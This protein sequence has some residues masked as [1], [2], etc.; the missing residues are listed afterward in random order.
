MNKFPKISIITPSYNQGQ[1]I[2]ETINSVLS[3]NYPNL[4]Y[5]IIDGG[6]NDNTVDV[7]K[8]YEKYL[9]YWVSEADNGQAHAIN[10]GF[11]KAT[12]EII[13][14]LNSDDLL[15]QGALFTIANRFSENQDI[16]FI[17]GQIIEFDENGNLPFK[18]FPT[19]DLP[20]R[21]FYD[22]PYAQ[23]A[24]FYKK[25]IVKGLG[26]LDENFQFTMD[27]DLFVRIL[28]KHKAFQIN[29]VLARFRWHSDSKSS[30]LSKIANHERQLVF[31]A[32]YKSAGFT[33]S[34]QLLKQLGLYVDSEKHYIITHSALLTNQ[35]RI[36]FGY[37]LPF[38]NRYYIGGDYEKVREILRF[39]RLHAPEY[40]KHTNIWRKK[41]MLRF[42]DA[43]IR[44]YQKLKTLHNPCT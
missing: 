31:S 25:D 2:E 22:F 40:L 14:W 8:K 33:N 19:K 29:N 28:S 26:Y 18:H 39:F 42:P 9:T 15:E 35:Y 13:N 23:P 37:L 1:Y 3:Q 32:L 6:S 24:C 27:L 21:Y 16:V 17:Y 5:I 44:I 43:L 11:K 4:E 36:L 41:L 34:I 10:K 12:G 30:N 20:F 38:I 7:I